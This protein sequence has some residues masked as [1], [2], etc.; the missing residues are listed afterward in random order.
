M[1]PILKVISGHGG[2]AKIR[3]YLEKKNRALGRDFLNLPL[4]EWIE[5]DRGGIT[6]GIE[7]DK[8]MDAT[9]EAFG[10]NSSWRGLKARTFKHFVISPD[11]KDLLDMDSLRELSQA[12]AKRYFPEHEIA[13]IYH[14]DNASRIPHAHVVVNNVNLKTGNRMHTDHPEDLNRDLQDMARERGLTGLF[15]SKPKRR[16]KGFEKESPRSLQAVYFGRA[17]KELMASGSY[18]WVGDI[19]S[20]V[21]LAKNTSRTEQEFMSA[22]A[23]LGLSVRDNSEKA[24]RQDWVFSLSDDPSKCVSGERLGLTYGKQMVLTRFERK[25]SYQPG[26]R[27]AQEIRRRASQAVNLND[28]S[29]LSRLSAVIETCAK[30]NIRSLDDFDRRLE[31]LRRRGSEQSRGFARLVEAR[32]YMTENNLMAKHKSHDEDL[33]GAPRTTRFRGSQRAD[34]RERNQEEQRARTRERGGR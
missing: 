16:A 19:R 11:P 2:T 10:T 18:S 7:W 1:M 27:S 25:E 26:S 23:K 33:R 12:W 28:L 31:T 32:S 9:R 5:E 24:Y 30:F 21:A 8:E 15:N 22:I 4:D 3:D 34:Q 14:D 20:R 13:I 17:E 6:L 29:D